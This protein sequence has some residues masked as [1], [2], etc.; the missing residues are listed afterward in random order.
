MPD[1]AACANADCLRKN[2]CC[3]FLMVVPDDSWQTY[4]DITGDGTDCEEYWPRETGAPFRLEE[5]G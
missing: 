2:T 4:L 5:P 1:Y 3:R